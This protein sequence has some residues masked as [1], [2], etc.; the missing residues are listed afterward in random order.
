MWVIQSLTRTFI[1]AATQQRLTKFLICRESENIFNA[2]DGEMKT[3][4]HLAIEK[5]YFSRVETLLECGAG[6]SS[7]Y[8]N[9][10]LLLVSN[11]SVDP[12]IPICSTLHNLIHLA[13]VSQGSDE[14]IDKV[15]DK[16]P[17]EW[18]S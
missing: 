18:V 4:L 11:I 7:N 17:E 13:T 2:K 10:A 15:L 12:G 8:N 9:S 1:A 3:A 14:D 5:K 6:V 16:I